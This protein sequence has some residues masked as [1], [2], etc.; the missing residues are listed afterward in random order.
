[1]TTT[2]AMTRTLTLFS[3]ASALLLSAAVA[4]CSKEQQL[5]PASAES[6]EKGAAQQAIVERAAAAFARMKQNPRFSAMTPYLAKA[7]AVMIFPRV[8]KASLIFGGE[9]GNGVMV[10]RAPDGS[11]SDPAFYSLGAP[12]VGL[13]VGYQEATM[14][15]FFMEQ[16]AVEQALHSDITLGTSSSLALGQVGD[17][18]QGGA[19]VLSKPIYQV[20]EAGGV[21][22]D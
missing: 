19:E 22:A 8:V 14:V 12:S 10:A 9:G 17:H 18:D 7:R 6:A 20:V 21:F 13:Q 2:I 11:W 1:M 15:L 5:T 4:G 3:A 16:Q